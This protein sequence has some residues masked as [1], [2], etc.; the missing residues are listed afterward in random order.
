MSGPTVL[1]IGKA[2][3]LLSVVAV[4]GANGVLSEA[5]RQIVEIHGWMSDKDFATAYAI[6][7]AAP[8]PNVLYA[9]LIGWRL[10]GLSGLATATLGMN[11][12]S[13]V[14]AFAVARL[15]RRY[16]DHG[17]VRRA[18]AALIPVAIGLILAAGL[19]AGRVAT[20]DLI[21]AALVLAGAAIYTL[22]DISP[23]WLLGAGGLIGM[24]M[25]LTV[26]GGQ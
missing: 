16:G 20:H 23:L 1:A 21:G 19:T 25:A 2:F 14:I 24:A 10:A 18:S 22:F 8:G 5:H 15:R 9:G 13:S 26:G 11:G 17:S 12:P 7:Q 4:G 3:A 6:A